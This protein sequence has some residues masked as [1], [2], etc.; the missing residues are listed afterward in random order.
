MIA[1]A[2]APYSVRGEHTLR[3][4]LEHSADYAGGS[5]VAHNVLALCL[6]ARLQAPFQGDGGILPS[7][8]LGRIEHVGLGIDALIFS[9]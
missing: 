8:V 4:A 9:S 5:H 3:R 2:A 7:S 6:S 1:A